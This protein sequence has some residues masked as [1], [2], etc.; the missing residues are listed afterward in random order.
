MSGDQDGQARPTEIRLKS[1][2]KRLEIDFD[3]ETAETQA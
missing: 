2:E 1:A 3:R